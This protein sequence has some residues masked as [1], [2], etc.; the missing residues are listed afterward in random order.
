MKIQNFKLKI[1]SIFLLVVLSVSALYSGENQFSL[2]KD[3]KHNYID[4]S[5]TPDLPLN[6]DIGLSE[7]IFPAID[8]QSFDFSSQESVS[9]MFSQ[10]NAIEGN[11]TFNVTAPLNYTLANVSV[12]LDGLA[13]G[14]EN[15]TIAADAASPSDQ[16]VQAQS[17]FITK[18]VM[19]H[20]FSM[21]FSK[22]KKVI[23]PNITIRR[24][25]QTGEVLFLRNT[26]ITEKGRVN[27]LEDPL[28]LETGQY[29]VVMNV[30]IEEEV[31]SK[32][33]WQ[34]S[35][36]NLTLTLYYDTDFSS[37]EIGDF[38]LGLFIYATG[39]FEDKSAVDV[40]I[41]DQRC[42]YDNDLFIL[43]LTETI[44][45]NKILLNFTTNISLIYI[46][47]ISC[48]YFRF[49]NQEP[50]IEIIQN[51][52]HFNF[53]LDL[54]KPSP[55]YLEY[56][57]ILN[58]IF[59]DYINIVIFN[60]TE[61]VETVARISPSKI[62]FYEW[63]DRMEFISSNAINIFDVI[64]TNHVGE[65]TNINVSTE[66]PGN[67]TWEIY[68]NDLLIHSQTYETDGFLSFD[69]ELTP[70]L[71]SQKLNFQIL[72]YGENHAG[73]GE[74]EIALI[75]HTN[76]TASPITAYVFDE[77]VLECEYFE[78]FSNNSVEDAKITYELEGFSSPLFQNELDQYQSTLE[79]DPFNFEPG[80]YE[81]TYTAFCEGYDP[82]SYK[83][84]LQIFPRPINF[85][86]IQNSN[87]FEA[88]EELHL[89]VHLEDNLDVGQLLNPVDLKISLFAQSQQ[90]SN[91]AP[92]NQSLGFLIY[93][94]TAKNVESNHTFL[95][96][97]EID[98]E[99]GNYTLSVEILSDTY[100]GIYIQNNF[101]EI[102]EPN[103]TNNYLYFLLIGPAIG[104]SLILFV[105]NR[106]RQAKKSIAG[107]MIMHE[108]GVL[109]G[110]KFET[111]FTD[112]DPLLISGAMSGMIMLIKEI[113]GGGIK[114][115]E[116][117]EGFVSIVRGEKY[118]LVLFLRN[119]PLWI[120]HNI[121]KCVKHIS[122]EIGSDIMNYSGFPI[123]FSLD[124]LTLKYFDKI[125][126]DEVIEGSPAIPSNE[127]GTSE[128][129]EKKTPSDKISEKMAIEAQAITDSPH[130][131]SS[132]Q[133][134]SENDANNLSETN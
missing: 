8:N 63:A 30:S 95:I 3:E 18:K 21:L 4:N 88:G 133:Y 52:L 5:N 86:I 118:W 131:P 129:T 77:I 85:E 72:F 100:N 25:S 6:S 71:N 126:E 67:I 111:N 87:V 41:N 121:R 48:T 42:S 33:H 104:T 78:F 53:S 75:Q 20:N 45:D 55:E 24:E 56:E 132:D 29:F 103:T 107:I 80:I 123:Q 114:T 83:T 12:S 69:W 97:M 92:Q 50:N 15:I 127:E 113:T 106:K 124:N 93:T 51:E 102:F 34:M 76:I 19:I 112:K 13:D 98:F 89:T 7:Q 79:L 16:T 61:E 81:I 11:S 47:D 46:Y 62:E 108:N 43:D 110:D 73:W 38:D 101:I 27:I 74:E 31:P 37:W 17:F 134:M 59:P 40:I 35:R 1:L 14:Y 44:E 130:T 68:E 82:Q 65:I 9:R 58:N 60:D 125:I 66:Y 120:Q 105:I 117:D 54:V 23:T 122:N 22:D 70:P 94:E 128:T 119:N 64:S 57:V 90:I 115:I 109:I 84:E 49:S 99:S 91:S 2:D 32:T 28:I 26:T 36:E 116:I 39:V 96:P 10:Q